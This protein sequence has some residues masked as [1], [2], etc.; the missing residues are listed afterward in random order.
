MERQWLEAEL[1]DSQIPRNILLGNPGDLDGVEGDMHCQEN[2][3]TGRKSYKRP[4]FTMDCR[5]NEEVA[6]TV[7]VSPVAYV[8]MF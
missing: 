2:E 3:T 8:R 7:S 1:S 5:A 6:R 4:T